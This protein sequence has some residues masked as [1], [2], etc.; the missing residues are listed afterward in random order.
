MGNKAALLIVDVQR[1]FCPGGSLAVASGDEIIPVIN[2]YIRTFAG[3]GLPILASRD[4]HPLNTVHFKTCGGPWPV[5]CVQDT[6][7]ARFHPGLT[8]PEDAIIFS[9]GMN[10]DRDDEYSGFKSVTGD[11]MHFQDFLIRNGIRHLFVCGLATD[12]CVRETVMDAL[13][14][15]YKVTLLED[16]VRGVDLHPGD[17]DRAISEMEA[18]GAEL[19]TVEKIEQNIDAI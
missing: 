14:N 1:D 10:P 9:K 18:A 7:G 12:Y 5:H 4:W 8:L 3:K 6:E 16:A 19:K 13:Q 2:R 15:G 17:S 11:G